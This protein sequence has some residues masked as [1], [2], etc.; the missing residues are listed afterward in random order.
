M[1][2]WKDWNVLWGF[3]TINI[4]ISR[5]SKVKFKG[6]KRRLGKFRVELQVKTRENYLKGHSVIRDLFLK[7]GKGKKKSR[8]YRSPAEHDTQWARES[9]NVSHSC[10]TTSAFVKMYDHLTNKLENPERERILLSLPYYDDNWSSLLIH[11]WLLMKVYDFKGGDL[12]I[13][14]EAKVEANYNKKPFHK[15][16]SLT[17]EEKARQMTIAW[18]QKFLDFLRNRKSHRMEHVSPDEN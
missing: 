8:R 11:N 16:S 10:V 6:V 5:E 2:K 17:D 7:A 14:T 9:P 3:D 18:A 1:E 15:W 4:F 12:Y 13:L